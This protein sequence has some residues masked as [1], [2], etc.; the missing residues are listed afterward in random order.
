MALSLYTLDKING[1]KFSSFRLIDVI[2]AVLVC[3]YL[4]FYAESACNHPETKVKLINQ[5][6][7]GKAQRCIRGLVVIESGCYGGKNNQKKPNLCRAKDG[8]R[9]QQG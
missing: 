7:L 9:Q 5:S 1:N 4:Q 3:F 2:V 8:S 6:I